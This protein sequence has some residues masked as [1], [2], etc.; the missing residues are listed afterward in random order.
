MTA[1]EYTNR[2]R[3]GFI[4]VFVIFIFVDGLFHPVHE[5][6]PKT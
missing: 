6:S 2:H 1:H 4:R 5:N 3:Q